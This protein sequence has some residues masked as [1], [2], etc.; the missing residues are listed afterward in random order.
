MS[1][2]TSPNTLELETFKLR[3]IKNNESH[4]SL[5]TDLSIGCHASDDSELQNVVTSKTKT[6]RKW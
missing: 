1:I 3:K 6:L 2:N 5:K 4:F